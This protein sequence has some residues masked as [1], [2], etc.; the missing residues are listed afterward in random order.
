MP[1]A[2]QTDKPG[3]SA[4]SAQT[5]HDAPRG[6][7]ELS[8]LFDITQLLNRSLNLGEVVNP[9]LQMMAERMG[10]LRGTITIL[11]RE[12]GELS[13]DAAF[14]LSPEERLRGRYKQGEG[15][16]GQ[17]VQTGRPVVVPRVSEEPLFLDRTKTRRRDIARDRKDI[18]FICVPI[19]LGE[20]TIG[21]LS[22]D[23]LFSDDIACTE[24]LRLLSIIAS[25]IAQA[26]RL[27]QASREQLRALE[28]ENQRLQGALLDRLKNHR[29]IGN[30]G[31]LRSLLQQIQQVAQSSTTVLIRGESGV[32]KELVAEA[33]HCNSPRAQQPFVKVNCAALPENIIESELFGHEKGAFT[34]AAATRKG[35]FEMAQGG[36]LFLDEIGDLS[37]AT[38]IKLLRV[39]QEREF[40]RLGGNQTLAVDVRVLAATNRPLE[41]LIREGRFR[42]DLFYRLNIFPICIPPLRERKTDIPSLVDHF[43]A[44]YNQTDHKR[45]RR[46]CAT[47][48]ELLLSHHWPG[49]VRELE[50]YMERAVLLAT[51]GV[52]HGYHLP[53]SLRQ[54]TC[55]DAT[56]SGKLEAM[57]QTLE[58]EMLSDALQAHHGNMAAAARTLGLTER[59]MGLRVRK[60]AIDPERYKRQRAG[61]GPQATP[62]AGLC[63]IV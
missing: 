7:Q 28:D 63:A 41:D 53:P 2:F 36:T 25:L 60:H 13:I 52:I 44:K 1:S 16:T 50:N 8:L 37:P 48:M 21:A 42:D 10:M 30:S 61:L 27:R 6:L 31:A 14:G 15:V 39:L 29:L 34:G 18:S 43:I 26:V 55:T 5:L 23:R 24:D 38:Q 11:D 9:L 51:D 17:V 35:R 4:R 49:N 47:A 3:L 40:E 20:E 33:I 57:L 12:T 19:R 56:S 22:A 58:Q 54:A 59:T 46:I 45:V 32:G 62:G